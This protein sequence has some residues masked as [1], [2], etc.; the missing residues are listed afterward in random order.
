MIYADLP[1]LGLKADFLRAEPSPTALVD[2]IML[3]DYSH[4]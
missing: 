2:N 3:E 4:A 1:K